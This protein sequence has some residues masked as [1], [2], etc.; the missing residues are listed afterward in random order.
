MLGEDVETV[1]RNNEALNRRD[2]A[3]WLASFSSAAVIDWSRSEG[4]SRAS[5]AVTA[6]LRS[7]GMR[8]RRPLRTSKLKCTASRRLAPKSW[9]RT[10]RTYGGAKGLR[11][12]P[13][14]RSCSQSSTGRS[15]A[16]DCSR[17]EPKPSK[18][19]ACGSKARTS[20]QRTRSSAPAC[21]CTICLA[22]SPLGAAR[23]LTRRV[24]PSRGS[25]T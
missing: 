19:P 12:S 16:F 5:I 24:S 23:S 3:T 7:S 15:L 8:S 13:E 6:S 17:R 11:W 25:E 21:R 14:A 10:L 1:R 9:S 18:V 2:L 22:R 20:P 4:R